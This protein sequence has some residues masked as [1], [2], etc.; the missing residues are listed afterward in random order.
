MPYERDLVELERIEN[1]SEV[2]A[3]G[4]RG[5]FAGI[6]GLVGKT[7]SLQLDCD[8]VK[9]AGCQSRQDF[10]KDPGA[11]SPPRDENDG[12]RIR[13]SGFDDS[14]AQS[15]FERDESRAHIIMSCRVQLTLEEPA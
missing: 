2:I 1:V 3:H 12:I 11:A 14:H 15:R 9:P 13:I 4:L 10:V 5:V 7:M 6:V 8:R